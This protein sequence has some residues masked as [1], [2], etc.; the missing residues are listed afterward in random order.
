MRCHASLHWNHYRHCHCYFLTNYF[1]CHSHLKSLNHFHFPDP[2]DLPHP[3]AKASLHLHLQKTLL[4]LVSWR[5]EEGDTKREKCTTTVQT[6]EIRTLRIAGIWYTRHS[7]LAAAPYLNYSAC[8]S[9][10]GTVL[11]N[12]ISTRETFK[13]MGY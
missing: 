8:C 12:P 4:P 11:G 13:P 3:S 6:V 2:W 9:H 7:R 1:R 10:A 5:R